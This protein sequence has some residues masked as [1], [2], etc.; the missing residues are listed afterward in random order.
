MGSSGVHFSQSEPVLELM[1]FLSSHFVQVEDL[2]AALK[3]CRDEVGADA[4][5][6][7]PRSIMSPVAE[8]LPDVEAFTEAC[9]REVENVLHNPLLRGKVSTTCIYT[10][11]QR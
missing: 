3:W 9:T 8:P 7:L 10:T 1:S 2:H 11:L 5:Y 6:A 4:W